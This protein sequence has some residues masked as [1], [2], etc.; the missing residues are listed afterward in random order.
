MTR[1]RRRCAFTLM[2]MLISLSI[3]AMLLASVAA[4]VQASLSGHAANDRIAAATQTARVIMTRMMRQ[5]RMADDIDSTSTQLT[6][7]PPDD[8]SGL[9]EI[10]YELSDGKLY[11]YRTVSGQTQSYILIGDESTIPECFF[12]LREDDQEGNPISITVRLG[13]A[14]DEHTFA[15]T[16]SASLRKRHL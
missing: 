5:V 9:T 1:Q 10:R 15:M 7:T 11:L 8:G 12:V 16:S 6:I 2:E 13:L 4:A 14:I 3:L